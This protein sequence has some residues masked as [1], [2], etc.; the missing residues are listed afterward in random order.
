MTDS[1]SVEL[2]EIESHFQMKEKTGNSLNSQTRAHV[3]H[4]HV[5]LLAIEI[6]K[7]RFRKMVWKTRIP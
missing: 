1:A 6:Y 5:S 2:D 3:A 4:E 7:L